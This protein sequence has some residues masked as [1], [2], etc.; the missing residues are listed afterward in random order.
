MHITFRSQRGIGGV[1]VVEEMCFYEDVS[2]KLRCKRGTTIVVYFGGTIKVSDSKDFSKCQLSS[3]Y[4]PFALSLVNLTSFRIHS[5]QK[6]V[7]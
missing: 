7:V 1:A 3:R 5:N 6:I 2:L 4:K